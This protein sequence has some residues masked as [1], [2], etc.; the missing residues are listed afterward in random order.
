M[1]KIIK[2]TNG[3]EVVGDVQEMG[4]LF[5]MKDPFQ[6]NYK[7]FYGPLPSVSL[8]KYLMFADNAEVVFNQKD[9]MNT[10]APRKAFADF[11]EVTVK[12]FNSAIMPSID[13]ELE[14]NVNSFN[15]GVAET[16]QDQ[17][18][19]TFLENVDLNDRLVN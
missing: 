5:I 7:Y 10:V 14:T 11:Y 15:E 12:Q 16:S 13:A 17:K 4:P 8:A 3:I 2:L 19:K 18:L 9:V 1:I 6:I